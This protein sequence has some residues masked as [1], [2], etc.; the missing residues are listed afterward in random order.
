MSERHVIVSPDVLATHLEGE[1]V[2]LHMGTKQYFR[3]NRTG[4]HIWKALEKGTGAAAI[5]QSLAETFDVSAAEAESAV[6]AMLDEFA[7]NALISETAA[8]H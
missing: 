8:D 7:A 6:R 4:A 3:L 5:A 2:L 1:A